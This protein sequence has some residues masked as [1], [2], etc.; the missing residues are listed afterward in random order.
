MN[1]TI[2]QL[3]NLIDGGELRRLDQEFDE[4]IS[5]QFLTETDHLDTV[6]CDE[7]DKIYEKVELEVKVNFL[8]R[9]FAE[10]AA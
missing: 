4:D 7:A 5:Q 1:I 3:A 8:R 9:F 10:V 2:Q 6:L